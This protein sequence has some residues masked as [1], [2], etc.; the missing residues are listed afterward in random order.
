MTWKEGG[1]TDDNTHCVGGSASVC[2][3]S[4]VDLREGD[5]VRV[6]MIRAMILAVWFTFIVWAVQERWTP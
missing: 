5:E 2:C 6:F 1:T 4:V 3:A